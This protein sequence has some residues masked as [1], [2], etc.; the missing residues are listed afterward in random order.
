[1]LCDCFKCILFDTKGFVIY[2]YGFISTPGVHNT[3]YPRVD[4]T[5][6]MAVVSADRK[7][8]L[9]GRGPRFPRAMWSCLAGFIEP[10]IAISSKMLECMAEWLRQWTEDH[11]VWGSIVAAVAAVALSKLLIH[12][13]SVLGIRWNKNCTM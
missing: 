12:T 8:L 4:P 7:R 6:I 3:S 11:G 13:A 10:G 5:A 9:L 2:R 1:M